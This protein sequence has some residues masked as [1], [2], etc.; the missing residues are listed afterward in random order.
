M[1]DTLIYSVI[2]IMG[3]MV[4][5]FL[6][7]C[8]YRLPLNMNIAHGHSHCTACGGRITAL[9]LVP[10]I[11]YIALRGRCGMC[12]VRISPIY[13]LVEAL[14]ALLWMLTYLVYGLTLQSFAVMLMI[15]CL[16]VASGTD[17][18]HRIIPDRIS[19]ILIA[20]GLA[21]CFVPFEQSGL[22]WWERVIG[23]F[24]VSVPLLVIALVSSAMG[25][26]DIKLM[27]GVGIILGWKLCVL[28]LF[29]GCIVGTAVSIVLAVKNKK[30]LRGEVAFGPYLAAGAVLSA[31]F[32]SWILW[33]YSSFFMLI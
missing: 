19:V 24:S 7:V 18:S 15:S 29:L 9:Y 33:W 22:F 6:N 3:L 27:A 21:M 17:L 23:F 31:L 14:N 10:L 4:G 25:G 26:G 20:L 13:P 8:I 5:S 12:G 16:I 30:P 32:G 1:D 28:S 11:S 2:M